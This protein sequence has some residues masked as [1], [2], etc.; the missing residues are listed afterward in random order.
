MI[1]TLTEVTPDTLAQIAE[2]KTIR[3]TDEL[4]LLFA[5]GSQYDHLIKLRISQLG[6]FCLVVDPRTIRREQ[7]EALNPTGIIWSGGPAS[8][9]PGQDK[10]DIDMGILDIGIPVLGI[11]LGF[12][13]WAAHVG[14]K[15][16]P[17]HQAEFGRH[18]FRIWGMPDGST[19]P[20]ALFIG[21]LGNIQ[22][23]ESHNDQV[24]GSNV[25]DFHVIGVTDR[26]GTAAATY[27]HLW[28]V[29]FHPEVSNT[30]GGILILENFLF[31]ICG[32]QDRFPVQEVA[33]QKIHEIQAK[34][35]EDKKI[36]IA[37]SGGKD[38]STVAWL[39]GHAVGFKP[40][41][42]QAI[43]IKGND[44]ADDEAHVLKYFGNLDW[45]ELI[46]YDARADY[47]AA[48]VGLTDMRE[49]RGAVRVVY[50][51][52]LERFAAKFAAH[53]IAQGTLYTDITE[54][55]G[56]YSTGETKAKIKQHHNVGLD[57][58]LEELTPLDT[59]VK[60]TGMA[61]GRECGVPD[62]ILASQPFPGPGL[63]VR[64]DGEVT[65]ETL[66]LARDADAI[67]MQELR[68]WG[69]YE[70]VWQT[71]VTVLD[72]MA[73]VTRGDGAGMGRAVWINMVTSV[74]GHTA[75]VAEL[76]FRF[77]MLVGQ[78]L[79]N[80]I[81]AIGRVAFNRTPKPPGTIEWG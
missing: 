40:G 41:R 6:V 22:V 12:Q 58:E 29:Q 14:C 45:L 1:T 63:I 59:E 49:K 54:S 77:E 18:N 70:S 37:L 64:I 4:F 75:D 76:P 55:G 20:P 53:F 69:L 9:H 2:E 16:Q 43:Y 30:E 15:I 26:C 74:D 11:C 23:V 34:I 33:A 66:T 39:L 8:A 46:V 71:A 10:V 31:E 47:L 19:T 7:V 5:L 21:L 78:R 51:P 13:L 32:A 79:T 60:D 42:I 80:E 35:G 68:A 67:V 57:F 25:R 27:R 24:N 61:I 81:P 72:S 52:I 3:R 62:E 38:S 17:D 48:L 44:R 56:G 36:L 73:T 50:K 65:E 28:G